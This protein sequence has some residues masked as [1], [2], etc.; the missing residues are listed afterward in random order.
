MVL[1]QSLCHSSNLLMVLAA[2]ASFLCF[3]GSLMYVH[4]VMLVCLYQIHTSN[5]NCYCTIFW[6]LIPPSLFLLGSC[7]CLDF[8]ALSS[9]FSTFA[10]FSSTSTF[11]AIDF[12]SQCSD[13]CCSCI[14]FVMSAACSCAVCLSSR[15]TLSF[16]STA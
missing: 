8:C 6:P 11:M 16:A 13:C 2:V 4:V 5:S 10:S 14:C 15:L 12:I 1:Y 9:S 3:S 7:C